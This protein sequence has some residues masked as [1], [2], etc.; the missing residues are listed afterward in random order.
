MRQQQCLH[1]WVHLLLLLWCNNSIIN[2]NDVY[3]SPTHPSVAP[4]VYDTCNN[5]NSISEG[6][7]AVV[8][9][10][11]YYC[12]YCCDVFADIDGWKGGEGEEEEAS[13]HCLLTIME[14]KPRFWTRS[15]TRANYIIIKII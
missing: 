3:T 14:G 8:Y 7:I 11:Y 9:R 4:R 15:H 10:Y 5:N 13:S 1:L 12:Y 6:Y 2:V